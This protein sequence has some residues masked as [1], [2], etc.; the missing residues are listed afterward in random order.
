MHLTSFF[1]SLLAVYACSA[2]G[3]YE[4]PHERFQRD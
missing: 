3:M 4:Q 2:A 1:R